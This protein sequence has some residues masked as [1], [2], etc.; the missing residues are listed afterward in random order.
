MRYRAAGSSCR[1]APIRDNQL[2]SAPARLSVAS[3]SAAKVS[4]VVYET[5]T[6]PKKGVNFSQLSGL[7]FI[8]TEYACYLFLLCCSC[9][10]KHLRF[11]V[12]SSDRHRW[13]FCGRLRLWWKHYL[14]NCHSWRSPSMVEVVSH[15]LIF[16]FSFLFFSSFLSLFFFSFSP[17]I[18]FFL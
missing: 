17:L 4:D 10:G 6:V 2:V 3:T 18:P 13:K 16:S 11:G 1:P 8:S 5:P 9:A 14:R 7:R 12:S 15:L